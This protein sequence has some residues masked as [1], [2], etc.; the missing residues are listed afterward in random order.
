MAWFGWETAVGVVFASVIL[1]VTGDLIANGGRPLPLWSWWNSAST[2]LVF[3]CIVW[4]FSNLLQVY[5]Q[6]EQRVAERTAELSRASEHRRHLEHELL[7]AS[8]S[9]RNA[10]GQ[11]L[12][13][14]ICQHLVGTT[15]AA[16]VLAQRLS[17]EHNDLCGDARGSFVFSKK[18]PARRDSLLKDS[19][20]LPSNPIGFRKS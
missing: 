13:D 1:R 16:K 4:I 9:E 15:L 12:H 18:G 8:S 6:L 7:T 14:D 19:C 11:E 20:C 10:M 17:H 2:L 3:L 5:R